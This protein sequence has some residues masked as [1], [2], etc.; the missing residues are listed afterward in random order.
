MN[1]IVVGYH[2]GETA[3]AAAAEA[4]AP[5]R[6]TGAELH[7]VNVVDNDR[8]ALLAGVAVFSQERVALASTTEVF[9]FNRRIYSADIGNP[10]VDLKQ[11]SQ[12][13]PSDT[14]GLWTMWGLIV[15]GW[16]LSLALIAAV[17]GLYSQG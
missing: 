4:A 10:I 7:I 9:G 15:A 14:F 11:A 6:A 3:A 17:S 1:R 13:A 5:A 12:W 16:I 2:E 8:I